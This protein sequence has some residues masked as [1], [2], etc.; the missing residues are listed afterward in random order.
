MDG[1]SGAESLIN[2]LLQDP[3]LLRALAKAPK[4]EVTPVQAETE[5]TDA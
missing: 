3:A 1:K 4:P 2:Q 5:Q